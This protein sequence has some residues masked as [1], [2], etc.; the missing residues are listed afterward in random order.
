G[1]LVDVEVPLRHQDH[2]GTAGH[3]GVQRDPAGVP[4]H[5]L[6]HQA[7][8]VALGGGVQP[9][10]RLHRDVHGRVEAEGVVG[11]VQVVVDGLGYAHHLHA[12]LVELGGHPESVL[13]AD[14]DQRVHALGD[15][16]R[17]DLLHA[18]VDLER[19]GTGGAEDGAATREDAAYRLHVQRSGEVLQRAAPPVAEAYELVAELADAL[20]DHRSDHRVQARAVTATGEHADSHD[21]SSLRSWVSGR[22]VGGWPVAWP[23]ARAGRRTAGRRLDYG[24]SA[25]S[26]RPAASVTLSLPGI[27][28]GITR[29]I[30]WIGTPTASATVPAGGHD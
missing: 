13:P 27:G 19:V 17:L 8:V 4:A 21:C 12:L 10:D 1:D 16:V 20:A 18:A 24:R 9:V 6:H 25:P 11:G 23:G 26:L 3:P 5:H 29:T 7:A 2:V 30:A 14:R 28:G 22:S 15:Q